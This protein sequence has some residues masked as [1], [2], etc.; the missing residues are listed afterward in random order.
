[1]RRVPPF[2][3]EASG[4]DPP[5]LADRSI[6]GSTL[7]LEHIQRPAA[8][9]VDHPEQRCFV[10]LVHPLSCCLV[11]PTRFPSRSDVVSDA[12]ADGLARALAP[13]R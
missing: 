5:E 6:L 1:M 7:A 8:A 2:D 9:G 12:L 4:R 3:P 11:A 10:S 13:E